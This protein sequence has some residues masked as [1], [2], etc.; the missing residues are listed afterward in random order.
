MCLIGAKG[1]RCDVT[2]KQTADELLAELDEMVEATKAALRKRRHQQLDLLNQ[3]I[4]ALAE[5]EVRCAWVQRFLRPRGWLF[6]YIDR[7]AQ[8]TAAE[9][10]GLI[11]D[12]EEIRK[13]MIDD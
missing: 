2:Q 7:H 8:R 10:E 12:R 9:R 5:M 3:Q 13:V 4:N 6:R 11:A 1:A